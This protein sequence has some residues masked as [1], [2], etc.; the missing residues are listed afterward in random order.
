MPE[1]DVPPPSSLSPPPAPPASAWGLLRARRFGP[2]FV[3]QFSGA[4]NDN[5]FR[6]AM[7]MLMVTE[8]FVADPSRAPFWLAIGGLVFILPFFLF[9]AMA[10]QLADGQDKTWLIRAIKL[11]EIVILMLGVVALSGTSIAALMGVLFLL[12]THSAFFGP[13]KYSILPQH[14]A[15][16]ELMAGNAL[17]ETGTFLAILLGIVLGTQLAPRL[18]ADVGVAVA[19]LGLIVCF[20]I[21]RAPPV[22]PKLPITLNIA[23]ETTELLR[24]TLNNRTLLLTVLGISWF[25]ALGGLF[26]NQMPALVRM[27]LHGDP[28]VMALCLLAFTIGIAVGAWGV[29]RLLNGRISA[30]YVPIAAVLMSVFILDLV[31]ALDAYQVI[32]TENLVGLAGFFRSEGGWRVLFDL[33]GLA[34]AGGAFTVPLYALLQVTAPP[35]QTSRTIAANNVVNAAFMVVFAGLTALLVGLGISLPAV[36]LIFAVIN[37]AVAA[38]CCLLLP[39]TLIKQLVAGLLRLLYRVEVKG[40]EHFETAGAR[41]VA[42]VNHVSFLDGLLLAAFLPGKPCFAINTVIARQWWVKPFLN[43]I[44][45]FPVDPLNPLSLKSMIREVEK[46][47]TLVIF[48]E[49]RL[50]VTGALMK[51]FEGPAMVA[52]KAKASIVPIRIDGAQY[53]PFSRLRGKVRLRW[54]PKITLTL[55][56]PRRLEVPAG[57][58]P[59]AARAFAGTALYDL[60]SDLMFQT[61][62]RAQTLPQALLDARAVHGASHAILED[63][64][65]TPLSYRRFIAGSLALGKPLAKATKR[66]EIVGLFLPNLASTGLSLFALL[67]RGRVPALLNVTAGAAALEAALTAAGIRT[68]ITSRTFIAKAKLEAALAVIEARAQV[69]YL[70]D[71]RAALTSWDQVSALLKTPL[72]GLIHRRYRVIPDEPA[73]VL[74]TSGSEGLPKGVVLTHTNLLANRYQLAA[75]IDFNA[76]DVVLNALPLFHAFGFTGGFLLPLLSGVKTLLYPSPLH[77]KIVPTL[78]YD[79]NATILFGTDTFLAGYA[80]A[81][82]PYDFYSVRYVFAGAERVKDATRAVFA[83]K[84]GLRI[85]EGYGATETAPV[86]AVNTPMQAKAGTVGRLLPGI[87]HVLEPVEGVSGGRLIVRGPNVMAGYVM[88]DQPGI[89]QPPVHAAQGSGWY[90]TGDIVAMDA[91]GFVTILGRAKRFAKIAGEMVS[92]GAIEQQAATLWPDARHAAISRPDGARGEQVVL[93]TSE[94]GATLEALSAHMR[95]AGA[96]ALSVPARLVVVPEVPLL[97]SGKI[98]YPALAALIA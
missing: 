90:D 33:F 34:V 36:F 59:Q 73:L 92:L 53:T 98:D 57:L 75:R 18:S 96:A 20:W 24:T 16:E 64:E 84:F 17:I 35:D 69:I 19:I 41:S 79:A 3:T 86:L 50:T 65:R 21:P 9:S 15:R 67:M 52:D 82:H 4:L 47:R 91:E 10:G 46:G 44:T 49:G 78:A 54:F 58:D 27:H 22:A 97:G 48:P 25:W 76:S 55:L 13:I 61:W 83:E 60:M 94:A 28:N 38:A 80:E 42:V 26:V 51:V 2:L 45:A 23:A 40:L 74:F 29:S 95:A 39:D 77:F 1:P 5:L 43:L 71:V 31:A 87:E 12:G 93:A 11:F 89:V 30:N 7:G 70:E 88:A 32:S 68:V 66:S 37:V 81:A 62:P 6:T 56:P 14:L 85:L 72:A 8:I 63:I